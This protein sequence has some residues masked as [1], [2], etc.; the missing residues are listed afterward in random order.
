MQVIMTLHENLQLCPKLHEIYLTKD[1][2]YLNT[3]FVQNLKL[4]LCTLGFCYRHN[5]TGPSDGP[6]AT[7]AEGNHRNGLRIGFCANMSRAG[8]AMYLVR[9]V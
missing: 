9:I 7:W 4:K 3:T 2:I 8:M 6:R 1:K 5:L